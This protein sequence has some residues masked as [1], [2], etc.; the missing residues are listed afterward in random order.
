VG[1][2][3]KA[4]ANEECKTYIAK[5]N[6]KNAKITEA[7]AAVWAEDMNKFCYQLSDC[8]GY[9]NYMGAG[10]TEGYAAYLDNKRIAG[11]GGS[12]VLEATNSNSST[13][14]T[15]KVVSQESEETSGGFLENFVK[16]ITG[17]K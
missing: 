13:T 14:T 4:C 6:W 2:N 8:G 16:S 1:K 9:I 15:G 5:S 11:S 10:T 7:E 12:D 17:R 3:N